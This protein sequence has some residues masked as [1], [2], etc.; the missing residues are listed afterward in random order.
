MSA[1]TSNSKSGGAL[2]RV[3]IWSHAFATGGGGMLIQATVA[4]YFSIFMTDTF[5]VPAGAASIIMFIAT[6]WDAI[7][8]P[9]MGGIC[10]RTKSRWGRYRPYLLFCPIPLVIVSYFLFL[11]PSGMSDGGKI[12]YVAVFYILYGMLL[13]AIQMPLSALIPAM[14]KKDNER[15]LIIQ[16][17]VIMIAISF[18]IA[19]SFTTDF[20]KFFGGKYGPLILIY[21]I[22][23]VVSFFALFK[24]A[25]E[26]Y[27]VEAQKRPVKEDLKVL[28]RHKKLFSILLV[29]CMASL[30]Y[31]C[32]FSSSV[33]YIMYYQARPDLIS[34]YMLTLSMGALFSMLVAMPIVLKLCK[35]AQ[36]ALQVTQG[37]TLVCY[38][39]LF[40]YG[41][42]MTLLFVLSFIAALAASM[43]QGLINFLLVDTIDYIQLKENVSMNGMLSAIKGFAY[44][45]G[46]TLTS[47][48]ILG[49]LA[50]SGYV[51]NDIQNQPE[52]ALLAINIIRFALPAATCVIIIVCLAFY[53]IQKYYPEIAKMK[54]KMHAIDGSDE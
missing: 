42:N 8:D 44:K 6:L 46:S 4:S 32:M 1:Q 39:V 38:L 21:G 23:M 30:G 51:A 22:L 37:I 20:V 3:A 15:S 41:K 11:A 54:E 17:G 53:P 40:I 47:S 52:S 25:K 27:L 19:S 34:K 35:T 26:R 48:G 16:L 9:I 50:V 5:G 10:D 43:E 28:V 49:I 12:V 31:G 2:S 45:C 24:T 14:T 33:Y 36:R 7:N 18:T 13:T 29:W